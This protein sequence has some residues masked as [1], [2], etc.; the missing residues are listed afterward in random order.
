MQTKQAHIFYS[1]TVQ[2]V[3]FRYRSRAIALSMNIRG[4]VKNLPDGRVEVTAQADKNDLVEFINTV[5]HSFEGYIR[6]RQICWGD[7]HEK[8]KGFE[9]TF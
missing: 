8:L 2:G 5:D 9:I 3:G 1:G 7:A 6:N 4:W